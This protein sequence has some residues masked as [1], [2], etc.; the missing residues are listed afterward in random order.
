MR[1]QAA[2]QKMF[3]RQKSLAK[4]KT[5]LLEGA[6]GDS[7]HSK[8]C[9]CT[10]GG[11]QVGTVRCQTSFTVEL[12][13]CVTGVKAASPDEAAAKQQ[14]DASVTATTSDNQEVC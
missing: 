4:Q 13:D 2:Q 8:Q 14:S 5:I 11:L 9:L 10:G 6:G 7:T 3:K 12:L 1:K